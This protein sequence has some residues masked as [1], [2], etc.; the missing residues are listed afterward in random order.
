MLLPG[1]NIIFN[2]SACICLICLYGSMC[3]SLAKVIDTSHLKYRSLTNGEPENQYPT[4]KE[5]LIC[6]TQREK[7]NDYTLKMEIYEL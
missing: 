6:L 7:Y 1:Q 3:G 5:G 2:I 4:P